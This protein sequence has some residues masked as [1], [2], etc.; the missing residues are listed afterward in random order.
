MSSDRD[1]HLAA[2]KERAARW[3]SRGLVA[4]AYF[5]FLEDLDAHPKTATQAKSFCRTG[6]VPAVVH[7]HV[8]T[9]WAAIQR[10]Q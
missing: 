8:G 1:V 3:L 10:I 9:L 5:S 4:H 6:F 7:M 2:S